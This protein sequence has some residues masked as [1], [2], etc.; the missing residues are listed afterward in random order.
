[1]AA[2]MSQGIVS[3]ERSETHKLHNPS[4]AS[5]FSEEQDGFEHFDGVNRS[6]AE[7]IGLDRIVESN[8][9]HSPYHLEEDI[10]VPTQADSHNNT[11]IMEKIPGYS[12]CLFYR[13]AAADSCIWC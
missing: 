11:I 7:F 6:S 9:D 1:M 3:G 8:Y 2:V 4:P 5:C 12:S 13:A 10:N